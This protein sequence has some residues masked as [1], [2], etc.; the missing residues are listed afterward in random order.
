MRHP[1]LCG[2]VVTRGR[3]QLALCH[4]SLQNGP[5]GDGCQVR[6]LRVMKKKASGDISW[7]SPRGCPD[8]SDLIVFVR[9]L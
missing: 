3:T 9:V 2:K 6:M 8:Q 7:V 5:V 4:L 1:K